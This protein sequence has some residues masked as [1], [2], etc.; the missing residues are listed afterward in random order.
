MGVQNTH[1]FET[2]DGLRG[3][4]ALIVVLTHTQGALTMAPESREA[5]LEWLAPLFNADG[6]VRL[7]FLLSGFVLTHSIRGDAPILGYWVKRY[8]R[9]Q[10]PFACALLFAWLLSFGYVDASR[11]SQWL[12]SLSR[13]H[14]NP[15]QLIAS[16]WL[17]GRAGG[18]LSIG[19]TLEIEMILSLALPAMVWLAR[20]THWLALVALSAL[21]LLFDQLI[22][23]YALDFA[24]G[25]V[26]YEKREAMAEW[27][28]RSSRLRLGALFALSLLAWST[29]ASIVMSQLPPAVGRPAHFVL[30][31]LGS[32]GLVALA[33][34]WPALVPVLRS[35][36]VARVGAISYSLYL[37]HLPV[38][39]FLGPRMGG[40][41][42]VWTVV[43]LYA[44]VLTVSLLLAEIGYRYIEAP[45]IRAGRAAA[46]RIRSALA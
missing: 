1:R 26:A 40:P 10:L 37:V 31:S 15:S 30:L 21:P 32:L 25:I 11:L 8:L 27:I 17:P 18:Q 43:S 13:I 12:G 22:W 3:I 2:L 29:N 45:S 6:A 20:R 28:G 39:T 14:L 9:I 38:V 33:A 35:R 24:L 16:L 5:M 42:G 46:S 34:H 7:F 41:V 36:P 4:A 19:W 44:G 23:Q